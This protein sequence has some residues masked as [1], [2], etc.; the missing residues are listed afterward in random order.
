MN[1]CRGCG[2]SLLTVRADAKTCSTA[3]RKRLS[4][5]RVP[6]RLMLLDRW[7]RYSARKVPLTLVG[8]AAS[9]TDPS[10]WCS[11]RDAVASNVGVG[12]GFVL[13][14]DGIGCYDL[15]HVFVG[16][17]LSEAAA[18]FVASVDFFYAEVSP[19]GEGLHLWVDAPAA[20]GR[21][22]IVDG[23]SVEFYTRG[24]YITVTGRVFR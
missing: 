23:V 15:D 24:R 13:N 4:R 5:V 22:M 7:V 10:T 9:S 1:R 12:V 6:A 16:G 17:V 3:C 14:G 19:S 21:K 8:G 2:V 20:P 11:Y 18:R